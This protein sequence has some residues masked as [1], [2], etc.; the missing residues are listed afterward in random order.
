VITDRGRRLFLDVVP[1]K[2]GGRFLDVGSGWGQI[3]LPLSRYGTVYCLDVTLGR[4][5][6]LQEIARQEKAGLNY[7]CGNFMTFPF[8]REQFDLVIFNGALEW[9]SLGAPD[10]GI[11]EAQERALR[12]TREILSPGGVVY[13]GIENSLGLKYLFGA[14]DDHTGLRWFSF[15]TEAD[16]NVQYGREVGKGSLRAKTWSLE[17]YHSMV[18]G[19]GLD[20]V[21]TYGCFPDYKIIRQIIPILGL[22]E[23]IMDG[24]E[25]PLEHSGSDGSPLAFADNLGPLYRVLAQ[26]GVAHVFCP[27]YGIVARRPV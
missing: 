17:E 4:L 6:I 2:A 13:I 14:P 8:D 24:R 1:A 10:L 26:N 25:F 21:E 22:N 19:A 15:L 11:R 9:I 18:R 12:K 20:L 7:V 27:S 5:N 23:M 3:A 16:A